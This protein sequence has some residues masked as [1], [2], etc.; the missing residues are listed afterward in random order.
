ME[1]YNNDPF[2]F[3]FKIKGREGTVDTY[4]SDDDKR[5]ESLSNILE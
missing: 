4:D 5:K 2:F 1:G 3:R